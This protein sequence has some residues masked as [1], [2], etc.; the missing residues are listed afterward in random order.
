M[1]QKKWTKPSDYDRFAF[2]RWVV[3]ASAVRGLSR[4]KLADLAG[5]PR[6][7][8]NEA[9]R[10]ERQLTADVRGKLI[11]TLTNDGQDPVVLDRHDLWL[12]SG[13]DRYRYSKA[14]ALLQAVTDSSRSFSERAE[15]AAL[16]AAW[17][18]AEQLWRAGAREA[19]QAGFWPLWGRCT[20]NAAT[21]AHHRGDIRAARSDCEQVIDAFQKQRA[22]G[23]GAM[24]EAYVRLGW[25]QYRSSNLVGSY[26]TLQTS[27]DALEGW[28][29]RADEEFRLVIH[30]N[31]RV[32]DGP[33]TKAELQHLAYYNFGR[34]LIEMGLK[35]IASPQV[36][37]IRRQYG[38]P[39]GL[40]R[41]GLHFLDEADHIERTI[42]Q[43][44]KEFNNDWLTSLRRVAPLIRLDQR[45]DGARHLRSAQELGHPYVTG[46]ARASLEWALYHLFR[47]NDHK[48]REFLAQARAEF[49]EPVFYAPGIA[50]V[51][52]WESVILSGEGELTAAV[53]QA[54]AAVA[55]H[56]YGDNV[57]HFQD[58]ASDL[59][60]RLPTFR[61][62]QERMARIREAARSEHGDAFRE[63]PRLR[64]SLSPDAWRT[65]QQAV[66]A[67]FTNVSNLAY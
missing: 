65:L 33:T 66:A 36:H 64:A 2:N 19:A 55:L 52:R 9:L 31:V 39:S 23:R 1:S 10:D 41:R 62:F 43:R 14:P 28:H 51:L 24:I 60:G 26:K 44:G 18:P 6:T 22:V 63:L 11:G 37:E 54:F 45:T 61:E 5:I 16:Q 59:K 50:D 12:I 8:L 49:L 13:I 25:G 27:I 21:M 29:P 67:E 4:T 42:L 53:E 34:T 46:D 38:G 56:P 3:D 15:I 40:L 20:L 30:Q 58:V 7:T 57:T 32:C 48:A 47:E 17:I 35:S